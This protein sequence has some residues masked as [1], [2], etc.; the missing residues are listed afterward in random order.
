MKKLVL[1]VAVIAIL[2]PN[3]VLAKDEP[4]ASDKPVPK[5]VA[6]TPET[7][8]QEKEMLIANINNMRNQELKVAVLQQLLS[9]QV[10]QL[11]NIQAVFCDQYK[12]DIE[13][14]R[15]G[16]YQYDE[17]QGKFVVQDKK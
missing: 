2:C 16:M 10:G 4:K 14:F 9:E 11:R 6:Q 17:K 15:N 1:L 3:F 7:A 5:A 13:K 8:K 12:L